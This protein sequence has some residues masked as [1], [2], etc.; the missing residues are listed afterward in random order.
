MEYFS[1]TI[2][3]LISSKTIKNI[4][5]TL[6]TGGDISPPS[7]TEN[8]VTFYQNYIQPNLFPIIVLIIIS[9]YLFIMYV[10]KRDKDETFDASVQVTKQPKVAEPA[11]DN[12][13]V[14]YNGKLTNRKDIIKTLSEEDRKALDTI[15]LDDNNDMGD[16]DEIYYSNPKRRKLDDREVYTGIYNDWNGENQEDYVRTTGDAI[17]YGTDNNRKSLDELAQ[18]MFNN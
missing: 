8:V 1:G 2:P 14:Q 10:L 17:M 11:V 15:P 18:M 7:W 13:P 5:K 3:E 6:Q 9:V 12:I 4:S 16:V